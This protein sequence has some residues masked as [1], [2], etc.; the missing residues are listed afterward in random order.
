MQ[1]LNNNNV[2]SVIEIEMFHSADRT[3][4]IRGG[5]RR[6]SLERW[7][8]RWLLYLIMILS[9]FLALVVFFLKKFS[10]LKTFMS[11]E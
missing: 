8:Y 2:R 11:V 5:I 1:R 4:R 6:N 10:S 3:E 9:V 7:Q